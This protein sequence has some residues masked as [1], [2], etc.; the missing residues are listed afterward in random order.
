MSDNPKIY[1][2]EKYTLG[3]DNGLLYIQKEDEGE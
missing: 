2:A 3:V 1:I